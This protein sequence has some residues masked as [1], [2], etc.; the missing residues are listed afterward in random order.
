MNFRSFGSI[1]HILQSLK[2][3]MLAYALMSLAI[4]SLLTQAS[5][6]QP[7]EQPAEDV[8]TLE[9]AMQVALKSNY[10]IRIQRNS[11]QQ[12]ENSRILKYTYLLP[13]VDAT[14]GINRAYTNDLIE[15]PATFPGSPS[16]DYITDSRN[17]QLSLNWTLFDGF[18]MFRAMELVDTQGDLGQDQLQA[19]VE[20]LALK[21]IQSYYTLTVQHTMLQVLQD[22][23]EISRSRY[24]KAKMRHEI[25]RAVR[26]ELLSA[27]V[28]WQSDLSALEQQSNAVEQAR[29]NLNQVLG[30]APE[31]GTGVVDSLSMP[32]TE[33]SEEYFM[34]KASEKNSTLLSIKKQIELAEQNL[35]IKKA[36]YWPM[37]IANGSYGYNW[38]V[39]DYDTGSNTE[40]ENLT[41]QVGLSLRWN[42]FNGLSDHVGVKNARLDQQNAEIQKASWENQL[43]SL[44]HKNW[45]DFQHYSRQMEYDSRAVEAARQNLEISEELFQLGKIND[46]QFREAQTNYASTQSRRLS[47]LLNAQISLT[48]LQQ[49]A[50]EIRI[51]E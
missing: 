35:G 37:L 31:E 21:V 5:F 34:Q 1:H 48:M 33:H 24:E 26:R 32:Q 16:G 28:A 23:E 30:R 27:E 7:K 43:R 39:S 6:A 47:T 49:L 19:Q 38:S 25:G 17:A 13:S 10:D 22:Q 18:R 41:G 29:R 50:G 42:L 51:E 46:T 36:N 40:R 44:V 14:A 8:L 9:Q 45:L 2:R 3:S 15:S 12:T 20:E 4:L 11:T